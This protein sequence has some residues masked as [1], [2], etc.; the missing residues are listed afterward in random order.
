[1]GALGA[2]AAALVLAGT[3]ETR[4]PLPVARSEVAGA[5]V[6]S[7]IAVVGGFLADGSN[8]ARA[9]LYS[10]ARDRWTRLPDLPIAVN[11]PMA[12]G[13]GGRLYVFGGY[14]RFGG[15]PLRDLFVLHGSH[16][17]RLP[18]LP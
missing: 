12:A 8:S 13:F 1:M 3:W 14:R 9:D 5:R 15:P 16:W 18:S 4:A 6:G 2:L 17:G 11:H 7:S 10:P